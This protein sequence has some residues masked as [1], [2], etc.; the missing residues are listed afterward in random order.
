MKALVKNVNIRGCEEKVNKRGEGY[1][2]VRFEEE[3]GAPQVLVDKDLERKQSYKRGQDMDLW[4]DISL[5]SKY[6]NV[7]IIS[8]EPAEG[9]SNEQG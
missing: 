1:L 9:T 2:L 4:I 6:V 3:S 8:A 5:G 7:R